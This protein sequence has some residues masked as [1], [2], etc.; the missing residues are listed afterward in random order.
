MAEM[1]KDL[2]TLL[3][4]AKL[5]DPN[6][7]YSAVVELL[8]KRSP[9]IRDAVFIEGNT[10]TGHQ[11]TSRTALPSIGW[12]R[13]NEGYDRSK[14][15]T[16]QITETCGMMVGRAVVDKDIV[17]LYGSL[18]AARLSEDKGF[19]QAFVQEA[20]RGLWYHSTKTSPEKFMG[21]TPRLDSTT[22]PY[23][24]QIVLANPAAVGNDNTSMWMVTWSPDTVFGITPKG[25]VAGLEALDMGIQYVDDG[26]GKTFPAYCMDW[27]WKLGFGV[28][29]A[30]YLV[31]IANI[32]ATALNPTSDTLIPALID[33]YVRNNDP[34]MGRTVIY[35]NRQ[36]WAGLWHQAR[37]N[38]KQSTL[39]VGTEEGQPFVRFMGIPIEITDGLQA[40]EAAVS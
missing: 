35:C 11:F 38:T 4:W 39:Q 7:G 5:R 28:K 6:G 15:R 18:E 21:L 29:D 2:P 10:V 37:N 8:E 13:F 12:R 16:A 17:K 9:T 33:A 26:T 23:G 14:G 32:D 24:D 25:F 40:T 30:R 1:N 31:R 19:Q 20:E 3:D 34:K 36:V 22:G 27:N